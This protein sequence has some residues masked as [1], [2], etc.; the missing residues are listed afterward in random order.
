MKRALVLGSNGFIGGHL[1][2]ELKADGYYVV[3]VGARN[4]KNEI[5]APDKFILGDLRDYAFVNSLFELYDKYD[6]VYQLACDMGGAIYINSGDFDGSVMSNSVTINSNVIRCI[7]KN[8]DKVL[9]IFFSSSA[10]V[11]PH[12]TDNLAS[13][14]EDAV[15]PAFPDNEY[16]WEKLFSERMYKSCA[17]QYG[18]DVFIARFHSIVGDYSVFIGD[19]AKAHSA[20]AYKVAMVEDNG[21]IEI[22]G[23]GNQQRTFLYVK[24]C[25]KGIRALMNSNCKTILNIGSD[26]VIS[27]NEYVDI[28]KHISGKKFNIKHIEGPIG[29]KFRHCNIEAIKKRCNWSPETSLEE[30]TRITYNYIT[31]EIKKKNKIIV[32]FVSQDV[33]KSADGYNSYCGIGIRGKLT[34]EILKKNN[35]DKYTFVDVFIN[36]YSQLEECILKYNPS[37]I[38]YNYHDVTTPYLNGYSLRNKYANIKHVMIHYDFTQNMVDNFNPS[39]VSGFEYVITDNECLINTPC[40]VFV[41]TRSIPFIKKFELSE[42]RHDTIPIIGFQGFG[43]S[44]KRID[45]LARQIQ[46][47]FDEAIFRLHM[48]MSYFCD[49]NGLQAQQ[50]IA[51]VRRIITKP[52]IKIECSH[53]FLTDDEIIEWLNGNTINCYFYDYLPNS[54]IASSPDYAIA[55]KRPLTINNS[56]MFVNLHGLEPSI[57]IEKLSLK[58]IIK[59]GT[60]PLTSLYEKYKHVN[61][62][63]DYENVCDKILKNN[64]TK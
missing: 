20:L 37:L 61:V 16:G 3:G 33:G 59:N 30:S 14:Q 47:E 24:D 42:E 12:D 34:S 11:Y 17:K 63:R 9:K 35:S 46:E 10:C 15:Y 64:T 23:D 55:A 49:P 36:N 25:I 60:T 44:H 13:C 58:E 21:T 2:S 4:I 38:I 18:L 57:E 27:I 48:P 7:S 28:L 41:V 29:V 1:V 5:F 32:L 50:R 40:N 62:I 19:R 52:G 39:L 53:T 26:K 54:G 8:K 43:L 45:K 22:I 56:R 31:N 51:E 6:E